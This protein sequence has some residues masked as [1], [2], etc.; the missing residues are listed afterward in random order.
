MRLYIANRFIEGNINN[1]MKINNPN[2][3]NSPNIQKLRISEINI[4]NRKILIN[5][6][7]QFQQK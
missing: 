4:D 6:I 7:D 2:R 1:I 5:K 3:M